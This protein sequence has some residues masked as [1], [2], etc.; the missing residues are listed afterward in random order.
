MKDSGSA[1]HA[2][3]WMASE[4]SL[5]KI[6]YCGRKLFQNRHTRM[7]NSTENRIRR[8]VFVEL[9]GFDVFISQLLTGYLAVSLK[10]ARHGRLEIINGIAIDSYGGTACQCCRESSKHPSSKLQKSSKLQF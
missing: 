4:P 8:G 9:C 3:F 7:T 6:T 10:T 1:I 2:D 5:E